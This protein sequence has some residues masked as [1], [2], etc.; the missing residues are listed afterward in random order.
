MFPRMGNMK[1]S[2]GIRVIPPAFHML[3]LT[4]R[5][6]NSDRAKTFIF[7]QLLRESYQDSETL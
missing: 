6:G 1:H 4:D 7:S 2:A 5:A 3:Q